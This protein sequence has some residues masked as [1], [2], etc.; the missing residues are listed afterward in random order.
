MSDLP[1]K[2]RIPQSDDTLEFEPRPAALVAR[3]ATLLAAALRRIALELG[4]SESD[5]LIG[6]RFDLSAWTAAEGLPALA[7]PEEV[8]IFN[9]PLGGIEPLLIEEESWTADALV[10]LAWALGLV[11]AMP[12]YD[13]FADA[14]PALAAIPAPWDSVAKFAQSAK[15]RP[16]EELAKERERAEVWHWRSAAELLARDGPRAERPEIEATARDVAREASEAGLIG[17]L[18]D[19]DFSVAGRAYRCIV[20]DDLIDLAEIAYQR[21]HALNWACGFG[22]SWTDVPLD[23][24]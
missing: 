8:D 9:A 22:R 16:D 17:P 10:A 1:L 24:E 4:L 11:D 6:E 3:R 5:D 21:L 18:V 15:L 7:A 19:G 14:A 23:V 2:P 13:A 20:E 12:P